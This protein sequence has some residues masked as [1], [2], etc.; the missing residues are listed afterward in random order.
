MDLARRMDQTVEVDRTVKVDKEEETAKVRRTT[1][2]DSQEGRSLRFL[3][4]TAD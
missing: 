2:E 1:A 4:P 3:Q